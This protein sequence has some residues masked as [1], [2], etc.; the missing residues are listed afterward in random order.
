MD[1][2]TLAE[3][4]EQVLKPHCLGCHDDAAMAGDLDFSSTTRAYETIFN[5]GAPKLVVQ[6]VARGKD[7]LLVVPG[8]HLNSFFYQKLFGSL[9]AEEGLIMPP[10][11]QGGEMTPDKLESVR[12]WIRAGAVKE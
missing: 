5:N 10:E 7:K 6:T 9:E 12:T 4:N 8:D 1:Q 11:E 2:I 3:L